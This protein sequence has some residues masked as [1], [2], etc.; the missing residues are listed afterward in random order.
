MWFK[1]KSKIDKHVHSFVEK[2]VSSKKVELQIAKYNQFGETYEWET[3]FITI[4]E[5]GCGS[6]DAQL[7]THE[8]S[9]N[10]NLNWAIKKMNSL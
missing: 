8:G 7:I 1:T 3:G 4:R 6:K 5:C 2:T 10:I 9:Y